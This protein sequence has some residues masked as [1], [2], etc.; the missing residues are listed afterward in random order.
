M[1]IV[2]TG[3]GTGGHIVPLVTVAKKLKEKAEEAETDFLFIGPKGKLEEELMAQAGIPTKSVQVGKM[4]R[5]FSMHNFVD[6]IRLPIGFIQAL[7][8]LLVYMPDAIFSKGGYASIPVV[9][10]GWLYRIPILIHESDSIPGMTNDILGKFAAR[11]AVSY[12][13]AEKNFAASQVVLT[14]NPVREDI[15]KGDVSSARQRFGLT[16]SKKVIFVY[17]GSQGAQSVNDKLLNILPELLSK[18]QVV[19]QTGTENYEGVVRKAAELGIKAGR[20][21]YHP[22]GFVGEELKDILAVSDLVITRAGANSLSEVAAN[23][24][25]AIVIPLENSA[26]NHQKMNAYSIAR[27]GGCVVL[28]ENNLGENMLIGK[29]GEMMDDETLRSQ[30]SANIK[31]F[32]HPDAAEKIADGILGMVR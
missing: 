23:G 1:R 3:G 27:K 29:I 13:E 5:Y 8:H 11:V 24:K 20:E 16:E 2:L 4:R 18:Y 31:N 30:L 25:P 12:E 28:E 21:G 10:A 26:S 9:L 6:M 19:H 14:G 22:T 7:W 17:G 32:Y 15:N